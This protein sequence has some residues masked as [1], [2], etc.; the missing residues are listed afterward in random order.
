MNQIILVQFILLFK[1]SREKQ[2][3]RQ[4]VELILPHPK[5]KRRPKPLLLSFSFYMAVLYIVN[6]VLTVVYSTRTISRWIGDHKRCY[7]L[8]DCNRCNR[9]YIFYLDCE[10]KVSEDSVDRLHQYQRSEGKFESR[11][12]NRW[13]AYLQYKK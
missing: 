8:S 9:Q 7:S 11:C 5:Q 12:K 2:L 4:G 13:L 1:S 3:A 6:T 10:K